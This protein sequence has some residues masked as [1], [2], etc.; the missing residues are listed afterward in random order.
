MK[1]QLVLN[2]YNGKIGKHLMDT[3][4]GVIGYKFVINLDF[5][6]QQD[7]KVISKPVEESID[8]EA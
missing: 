7:F 6:D 1:T 5:K 8:I 3:S 4:V 2:Y